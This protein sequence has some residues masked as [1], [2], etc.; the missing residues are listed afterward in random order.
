MR[1]LIEPHE[2]FPWQRRGYLRQA[3]LDQLQAAT[4]FAPLEEQSL[5]R[6]GGG[7][8][9]GE[10]QDSVREFLDQ[11]R[12]GWGARFA[13]VFESIGL[14]SKADLC[15]ATKEEM[16]ELEEKLAATGAGSF[17]MRQIRDAQF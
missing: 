17:H 10:E 13:A 12:S 5:G 3:M 8:G 6:G 16:A 15:V 11:Q 9:G 14:E 7:P 2:S 4:G 1:E